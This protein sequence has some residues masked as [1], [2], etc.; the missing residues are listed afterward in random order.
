Q[1]PV[2]EA[3]ELMETLAN[4]MHSAH[5]L[6]I[7]H[8]DLKPAN[9]LLTKTGLPKITD[10][11]LAKKTETKGQTE[12]GSVMGTPAYMPPEQ[13]MGD[14]HTLA[15][16]ADISSLGPI[17]YELITGQPPFL[18]ETAMD[19]L[20]QVQMTDP[21]RPRSL[22]PFLPRDLETIC[23]KCLEKEPARRYATAGE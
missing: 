4:A 22:R 3:A 18:G 13:A 17:L 2:H 15:R 1:Q 21:A 10:F 11:G 19:T 23:L 7:I 6:G 5:E 9:I 20:L 16:A 12:T 8:R 14:T